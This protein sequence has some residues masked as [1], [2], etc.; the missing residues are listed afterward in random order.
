LNFKISKWEVSLPIVE[1]VILLQ[2]AS[3]SLAAAVA[4]TLIYTCV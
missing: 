2:K 1:H 4:P 3:Q